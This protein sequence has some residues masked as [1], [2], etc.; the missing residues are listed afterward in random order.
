MWQITTKKC[1]CFRA[2]NRCVLCSSLS[3]MEEHAFQKRRR[4]NQSACC[5]SRPASEERAASFPACDKAMNAALSYFT[6]CS[7][8]TYPE[9]IFYK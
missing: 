5:W 7:C 1:R 2:K 9:E 8:K 4:S 3:L 6:I